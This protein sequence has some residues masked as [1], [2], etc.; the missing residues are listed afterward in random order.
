MPAAGVVLALALALPSAATASVDGGDGPRGTGPAARTAA[1]DTGAGPAAEPASGSGSEPS[2]GERARAKGLLALPGLSGSPGSPGPGVGGAP[3]SACGPELASP[4]RVEAQTCVLTDD[5]GATRARTY[6]HNRTGDTLHAALS[7][8]G[9]HGRTVR[10]RCVLAASGRPG[11]CQTPP[12]AFGGPP[13]GDH[14]AV[15]EIAA[16]GGERVLL[17][18]ASNSLVPVRR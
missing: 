5:D 6:Y 18:S 12:R 1:P 13:R 4:A 16:P 7:L 11:I 3:H 9:P 2:A 10:V 14:A 8:L 17:R 15:A